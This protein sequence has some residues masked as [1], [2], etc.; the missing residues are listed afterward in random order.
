LDGTCF[1]YLEIIL[2][3]SDMANYS[4]HPYTVEAQPRIAYKGRRSQVRPEIMHI[5]A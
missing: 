5:D 1:G 2:N 3:L 4:R